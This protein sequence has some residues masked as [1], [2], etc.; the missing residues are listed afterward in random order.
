MYK[1]QNEPERKPLTVSSLRQM[2]SAGQRIACLTAYDASFAHCAEQAGVDVVLV[3]DSLGMVLQGRDSTLAVTVDDIVYHCASTRRGLTAPLLIADMPFMSYATEQQAL[4]NAGRMLAQGGANMVKLE[5]A[6]VV[7]DYTA[8][9]TGLGIPVCGHLGLTPQSFNQLSGYRV[10]GKSKS[11][12]IDLQEDAK[13]LQQAGASLLVLECVPTG[14]GREISAALEIPVI[15]IGAGPGCDGQVLVMHDMLGI[16]PGHRPRFV[17]DF[18]A[19]ASSITEAMRLYVAA[20]RDGSY[21][22]AGESFSD[23]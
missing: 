14:L 7:V 20:V 22:T 1:D 16:T 9:L 8:R 5:G 19:G 3:G 17:R 11:Q 12:A 13:A 15:G 6:G 21:P 2:K 18:M 4:D 23:Q 10:Q